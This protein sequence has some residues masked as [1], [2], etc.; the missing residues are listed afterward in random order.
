VFFHLGRASHELPR[1]D[2][3]DAL[4]A[5]AD[6]LRVRRGVALVFNQRNPGIIVP[7]DL[8]GVAGLRRVAVFPD[9]SVFVP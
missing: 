3:I 2:E 9:G 5:F 4:Q 8:V 6:T 7:S 1:V